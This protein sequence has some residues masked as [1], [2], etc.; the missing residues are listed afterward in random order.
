LE[1][2]SYTRERTGWPAAHILSGLGVSRASYQRY[3]RHAGVDPPEPV[4]PRH[5]YT[6]LEE[7]IE[8]VVA[9]ALEY[10]ELSHRVLAYKLMRE[11][12][13]H[14][15]PSAVYHILKERGLLLDRPLKKKRSKRTRE[16]ANCPDDR[17]QSDIK[18]VRVPR[19]DKGWRNMYMISFMDEYSRH[20]VHHE[21]LWRMDGMSVSLAA[22]A[23]AD[24]L[25]KDPVWK[26]ILPLI[27]TDNGSGYI[28]GDFD[29]TISGAGLFHERIT[30]HCPEEN[31]KV[32]RLNRTLGEMMDDYDIDD[33][34]HAK[35]VVAEVV[36]K[37]NEDRLHSALNY[38]TPGDYYR[39]EPE[40]LL[41]ERREAVKNAR[42]RRRQVNI[43]KRKGVR[44]D[45]KEDS[46][47]TL[48]NQEPQTNFGVD[49]SQL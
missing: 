6:L 46:E 44:S 43:R 25:K 26:G 49:L 34:A 14:V 7:E 11:G 48:F 40:K 10:S 42:E 30:P 8:A 21:L 23:A 16:I 29:K 45:H 2:V 3:L 38:L 27:Q 13:A 4:S 17:W 36:M 37:Y 19:R 15:S 22:Q 20:I 31:G 39:G 9:G 12:R 41:A 35:E 5:P 18:Y 33:E 32:E 24:K 1:T 47:R 28:S